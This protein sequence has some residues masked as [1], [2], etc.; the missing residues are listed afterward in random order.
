MGFLKEGIS[1]HKRSFTKSAFMQLTGQ[2]CLSKL[3]KN[4]DVVWI[5][6]H[7]KKQYKKTKFS[8]LNNYFFVSLL[9]LHILY[10][11][12]EPVLF[13]IFK[14]TDDYKQFLF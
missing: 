3:S 14:S 12:N 6:T 2:N 10:L 1:C 8:I 11:L 5:G 9:I 13:F 4:F 7:L